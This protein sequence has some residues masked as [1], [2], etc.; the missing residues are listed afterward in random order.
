V[1]PLDDRRYERAAD[2]TRPVAAQLKPVYTYYPNTSMV[3]PLAAPAILGKQH[4]VTAY[5]EINNANTNGVLMCTGGEFGGWTFF[6][7]DGYLEYTSNYLQISEHNVKS[8]IK[9][10]SG[11]HKL[12]YEFIP[13]SS[14]LKPT[15]F[16]GDVK[17]FI[18]DKQVGE[19]TGVKT[20]GT[21][22]SMTGYGLQVGRNK[23]TAVTHEY[24]CPFSFNNKLNKVEV[25]VGK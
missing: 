19:L 25:V 10:P 17:L 11:A 21:Y 12:T 8:N 9:I 14:T 2:P 13:V 3:H 20:A 23:G 5:V 24:K 4:R 22:C 7:K 16:V 1:L 15:E 18:D 6:A